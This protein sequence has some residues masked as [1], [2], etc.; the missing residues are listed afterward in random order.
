MQPSSTE[1][2]ESEPRSNRGFA[3]S[4]GALVLGSGAALALGTAPLWAE[5]SAA[6]FLWFVIVA[7]LALMAAMSCW[8]HSRPLP[9][10]LRY[11]RE[12]EGPLSS[13]FGGWTGHLT[14]RV[15][16][17][18]LVALLIVAGRPVLAGCYVI[19][20]PASTA[21][22]VSSNRWVH[23][24]TRSQVSSLDWAI[25]RAFRMIFL[26]VKWSLWILPLFAVQ[27]RLYQRGARLDGRLIDDLGLP[28]T[29]ASLLYGPRLRGLWLDL[30]PTAFWLLSA[31][32]SVSLA[33][34][35]LAP[36]VEPLVTHMLLAGG[37][38]LAA[39]S[40]AA[41]LF[42]M[43]TD[44]SGR[45]GLYRRRKGLLS[46]AA[47]YLRLALQIS[48][49]SALLFAGMYSLAACYLAAMAATLAITGFG[50]PA[51]NDGEA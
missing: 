45:I 20:F 18:L 40:I 32:L 43:R 19:V 24:V 39:L 1:P 25:Y 23:G 30:L 15:V 9:E 46:A 41:C 6:G 5:R 26:A 22:A 11:L 49:L 44:Q 7:F 16:L 12:R 31:A 47:G 14:H 13:A 4:L 36:A 28:R 48:L 37:G 27:V 8:M 42:A 35:V 17:L 29:L 21:F 33:S 38:L 3:C 51:S 50:V 34:E 2:S 10:N